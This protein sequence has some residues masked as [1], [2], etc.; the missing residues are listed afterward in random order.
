M[1]NLKQKIIK[2]ININIKKTYQTKT[3]ANE[4]GD[5]GVCVEI[6]LFSVDLTQDKLYKD[7]T[8]HRFWL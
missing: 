3:D 7:L 6:N 2:Q 5:Q 4:F 1:Q 8:D